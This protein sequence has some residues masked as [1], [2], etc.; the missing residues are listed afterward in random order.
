M[1]ELKKKI[2][3]YY[4]IFSF[5]LVVLIGYGFYFYYS[6]G[7]NNVGIEIILILIGA[8]IFSVAGY[9]YYNK[10]K[11]EIAKETKK[12]IET[13][14]IIF[15]NISHDLKN[16]MASVFGFARALEENNVPE[17]EKQKVYELI[18]NKSNQMNEMILKMFQYA[19]MESE[20]YQLN[21]EKIDICELVRRCVVERFDELEK[22]NIDLD[23]DVP[24][25]KME[26]NLDR[27]E[28]AR[29]INNLITN[30]VKHNEAGIK[31]QVKVGRLDNGF[32]VVVADSGSVIDKSIRESV[33][34]P[35]QCSDKSRTAKD[36]SGLGLAITKRI[37][38]LHNG[39]ICI[40]NDYEGYTK[41]FVIELN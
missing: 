10:I 26:C 20:G 39:T 19:K 8:V 17:D 41:A 32:R 11:I 35:F 14:N 38:Q 1:N 36:G 40:K 4:L 6:A 34:E 29:V 16:P 25:E 12:Q 18:A 23:I 13:R 15:A 21:F 22:H 24:D 3:Y 9:L 33:F 7:L 2:I 28:F 30:A 5:I 31:V 37:V 27:I